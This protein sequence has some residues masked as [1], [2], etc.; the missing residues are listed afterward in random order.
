[1]KT[2]AYVYHG[3]IKD[4]KIELVSS[5]L[6][7]E[8]NNRVDVFGTLIKMEIDGDIKE[9]VC[10]YIL[11]AEYL[12]KDCYALILNDNQFYMV[13]NKGNLYKISYFSY[14]ERFKACLTRNY[15]WLFFT[16]LYLYKFP[17]PSSTF[18]IIVFAVFLTGF[19]LNENRHKSNRKNMYFKVVNKNLKQLFVI[20]KRLK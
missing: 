20:K 1:M 8:E 15:L 16:F 4:I 9:F 18:L 13:I 11:S 17:N 14:F 6:T 5:E 7:N 3:T 10:S 19:Y 12:D 2:E